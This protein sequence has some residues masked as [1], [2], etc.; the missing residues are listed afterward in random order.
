MV[1]LLDGR[2]ALDGAAAALHTAV[3]SLAERGSEALYG[4]HIFST[5]QRGVAVPIARPE[6]FRRLV[7]LRPPVEPIVVRARHVPLAEELNGCGEDD[8]SALAYAA[9]SAAGFDRAH[10]NS[11]P[12]VVVN[13]DARR[14]SAVAE[15][16]PS[17]RVAAPG[18]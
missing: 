13:L 4:Q 8:W 2:D 14:T 15:A 6:A 5:G 7:D 17:E 11:Q 18:A 3:H 12:L 9:L 10:F 16:A 1:L